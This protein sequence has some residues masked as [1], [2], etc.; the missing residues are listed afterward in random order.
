MVESSRATRALHSAPSLTPS[1]MLPTQ[2]EARGKGAIEAAHTDHPP[3]VAKKGFWR[4]RQK[5]ARRPQRASKGLTVSKTERRQM[6]A[7]EG[8][9]I[10]TETVE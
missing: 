7:L 1:V 10:C 6:K 3:K 8:V 9:K 2:Q 5:L 4:G